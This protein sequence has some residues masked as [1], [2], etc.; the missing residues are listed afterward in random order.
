MLK[1]VNDILDDFVFLVSCRMAINIY[2]TVTRELMLT[3]YYLPVM[4]SIGT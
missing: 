3:Q 2:E 1:I 4:A